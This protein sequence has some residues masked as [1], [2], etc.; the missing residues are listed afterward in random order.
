MQVRPGLPEWAF[1]LQQ[2]SKALEQLPNPD[3]PD[4]AHLDFQDLEQPGT[5]S[6]PGQRRFVVT[7]L[8]R[9]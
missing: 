6:L 7:H 1:L 9:A 4:F 3:L 5:P 2:Q 8:A